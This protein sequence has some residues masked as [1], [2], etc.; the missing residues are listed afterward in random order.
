[1][2]K[3]KARGYAYADWDAALMEAIRQDWAGLRKAPATH[4]QPQPRRR[5]LL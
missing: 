2:A 3:A 5:D 1:M 4:G